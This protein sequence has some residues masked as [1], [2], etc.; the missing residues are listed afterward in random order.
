M[1]REH[2]ASELFGLDQPG[3]NP[4]PKP[5]LA[6]L[7]TSFALTT[8]KRQVSPDEAIDRPEQRDDTEQ[9]RADLT[10]RERVVQAVDERHHVR[11]ARGPLPVARAEHVTRVRI[12]ERLPP[13]LGLH[14][15][16]H[17]ESAVRLYVERNAVEFL[18]LR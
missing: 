18:S 1:E 16:P 9:R 13:I 8:R 10:Q 5:A 11:A 7:R 12:D 6:W 2:E 17:T 4:A 3:W 15:D 14:F